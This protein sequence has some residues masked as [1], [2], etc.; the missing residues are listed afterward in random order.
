MKIKANAKINFSLC[1]KGKRPDGYHLI[2]TVM[3][4][5]DLFDELEVSKAE[6]ITVECDGCDIPQE[7]NIA[8]KAAKL[9]FDDYD[10]DG[11]AY[12]TLK[13]N[14][15]APAGLGGGSSDA[16]AVL[17]AL[18]SL[19][20]A[21]IPDVEL[22]KTALK[23]GADVPFFIEGGCK[24]AEGIGEIFTDIKPLKDG[25]IL[26]AKAEKKPSTGEMYRIVD[27]KEPI[28][29]DTEAVIRAI[30][31]NDLR[32]LSSELFNSFIAVWGDSFVR[33]ALLDQAPLAV[34]LSGSGP[35]WFAIFE[36]CE[37]AQAAKVALEKLEIDCWITR[38]QNKAIIFE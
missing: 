18:N 27:G 34:S 9:F 10:I 13:K 19:Y 16:A 35:T 33:K 5:I 25:Y 24:R 12:I 8:Y 20:D 3:H 29:G 7:E 22:E 4:S 36:T 32:A 17:L 2:D 23:L 21:K 1:V 26:L 30:E 37:K 6:G 38:P 15:P 11:G 28:V 14:I 31:N